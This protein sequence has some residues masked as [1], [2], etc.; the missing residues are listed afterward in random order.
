GD[1]TRGSILAT[2]NTGLQPFVDPSFA[3]MTARNS[4]DLKQVGFPKY[5]FGQLSD[6]LINERVSISFHRDNNEKTLIKDYQVKI[7]EQGR[8]TLNF[9]EF[10]GGVIKEEEGIQDNDLVLIKYINQHTG[11]EN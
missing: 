7:K 5:L 2:A 11:E 10:D 1:R 4:V 6:D 9:D 3:K 8:F